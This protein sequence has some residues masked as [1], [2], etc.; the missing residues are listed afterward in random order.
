M[1]RVEFKTN[2]LL[3]DSD[4]DEVTN[5]LIKNNRNIL[6]TFLDNK[7][8]LDDELDEPGDDIHEKGFLNKKQG[9]DDDDDDADRDFNYLRGRSEANS[10]TKNMVTELKD[11]DEFELFKKG[12]MAMRDT[13]MN[14]LQ[15]LVED[16]PQ[17][18]R[19]FLKEVLQSQRI[20]LGAGGTGRIEARRIVKPSSKRIANVQFVNGEFKNA[21]G[22]Q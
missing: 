9:G 7:K 12:I 19:E 14:I 18:K 21:P 17:K 13:R 22:P 1:E 2:Q 4:D 5:D 16:L 20:Q 3:E 15:Q 11:Q 8:R 6:K 10:I